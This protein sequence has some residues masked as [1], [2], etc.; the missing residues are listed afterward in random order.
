V[1]V[2]DRINLPSLGPV[3]QLF[4]AYLGAAT[5]ERVGAQPCSMRNTSNAPLKSLRLCPQKS[6]RTT[7]E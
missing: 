2:R 7:A 3:M 1:E 6:S 5:A 4:E